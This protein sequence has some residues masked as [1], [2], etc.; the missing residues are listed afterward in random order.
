MAGPLLVLG[1]CG[2]DDGPTGSE[3]ERILAEV[4]LN[5]TS[6]TLFAG[7]S[8]NI[9]VT[10]LDATGA[11]VD[12]STLPQGIVWASTDPNVAVASSQ[13]L[14]SALNEGVATISA[15]AGGISAAIVVRVLRVPSAIV[16]LDGQAKTGSV[17]DNIEDGVKMRLRDAVGR[18]VA[19]IKVRFTVLS[20]GGTVSPAEI[21]TDTSGLAN[22]AWKLGPTAGE[23]R[24][25]VRAVLNSS[26]SG[27]P[28]REG[29]GTRR[30]M[31]DIVLVLT[32][33][34]TADPPALVVLTP[35]EQTVASG[36]T[37]AVAFSVLDAFGNAVPDQS[38][39][40]SSSSP[41]VATPDASGSFTGMKAGT[42]TI[43]GTLV[44]NALIAGTAEVTVTPGAAAT[45]TKVSGD[46]Q[47]GLPS[48]PLANPLVV[49]V[50]DLGGNLLSGITVQWAVASGSGTLAA[51]SSITDANGRA[52]ATLTFGPTAGAVSV[53]AS[54][55]GP[56]P[57]AFSASSA[58]L[59]LA[60]TSGSP[61]PA[62]SEGVAYA[63][64]LVATGGSGANTWVLSGAP[65]WLSV[66]ASTGA[67]SGTA[68]P[69]SYTFDVEVTSGDGQTASKSFSLTVTYAPVTITTASPLPAGVSGTAYSHTVAATGGNGGF[70][71]SLA[72]APA[73]LSINATTGQLS[74]TAVGGSYSF[75]VN[76]ASGDGQNASKVFGLTVG[77]PT[78]SITTLA[79]PTGM[80]DVA[81]SHALTAIGGNGTNTWSL[82]GGPAWLTLNAS[83]GVLSGTAQPGEYSL[84]ISVSSGDGQ[85]A[86][87]DLLLVVFSTPLSIATASALPGGANGVAYALTFSATGGN[88]V[89]T[90]S[91]TGAPAWLSMNAST[92]QI[93]G[94]AVAGGYNFTVNVAS[95]DGQGA[96]KAVTLNV[97]G[98]GFAVLDITTTT[99]PNG[100]RTVAYSQTLAATGGNG[101]NTWALTAGALPA[102][103]S[104]TP[105]TGQISGTPTAAGTFNFT[106]QATS[107]DAQVDTQAL[108]I[109]VVDPTPTITTAS[110]PNGTRTVA[111]SQTLAA[112]GGDGV[113]YA[114][115]ITVGT[116]PAGLTLNAGTGQISGTPTAAGTSN[117]TVR[118]TSGGIQATRA[119]SI[120]VVH[121]A[122]TVTTA[123]LPNGTRTVAY[124]QTLAAT[125]G[126]GV[127]YTWAVTVGTLP[128]GLTLN[129]G[130]GQI[131][132]T[133]TAAGTSNFTVQVTSGGLTATQA[134]GI[135]VVHPAPTIT[136]ASLP[137]GTRTVAY[138]QT[139]A[140]TGG[141]GVT[142]AWAITVGTLPAGLTLNAGTGQIS[143]TP[144]AAGTSNFT[145][146]VTSGGLTATQALGIT[147]VHPAPSITTTTLP[148][149]TRTVAYSQTLAATAGDGTTYTW[150]V[151]VG[152]LPAGLT[153][154]AGTGQI[155]GTPTA[156]GTTNFTVQVTSGGLTAT[157]ALSITVVHP[158]PTITT[159]SLPNGTR[160]VAYNQSLAATGGDGV[161]YAWAI[162]AGS[163][164]AG[165]TLNAGTGAITGTPTAA[166]SF[167]VTYQ[168]TSGGLSVTKALTLT[169]VH[170]APAIT[171][172]TVPD[173]SIGV[174]Y[175][176]SVAATGG[177][178]TFAWAISAGA[179]PG[180]LTL[181]AGSGLISGTPTAPP[182]TF[183]FT[184]QVTSD[185]RTAT[186]ALSITTTY[187]PPSIQST[188]LPDVLVNLPYDEA[189][190]V[191]G[192]DGTF[193]WQVLSGSLPTG[194]S[195]NA[196]TGAISGTP[197]VLGTYNFTLRVTSAAQTDDQAL[198]IS[199]NQSSEPAGFTAIVDRPFNSKASGSGDRGT[200]SFPNK[201][202]GSEGWDDFESR[203]PNLTIVAG[204]DPLSPGSAMR[205]TYP[206]GLAVAN[207]PG[208]TQTLDFTTPPSELYVRTAIMLGPTYF[209]NG[210]S[211][212]LYFH[213]M[214]GS[215]RGEPFLALFP[216]T[217]PGTFRLAANFQG[218]PDNPLGWF[219]ATGKATAIERQR[220][221]V[222]ETHLVMNSAVGVKD[223]TFR[224]WLN[225]QLVLQRTDVEFNPAGGTGKWGT[226]HVSPTFGGG[227]GLSVNPT[228]FYWDLGH[229]Y[230]SGRN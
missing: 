6:L 44:S 137:N 145:V 147:V 88:G 9:V 223:G 148:N 206:V 151:T 160:T 24:L 67:L 126:D 2:D 83:T 227:G 182:G 15:T 219:D 53:T 198:S 62:G 214:T 45:L 119:L 171:T 5:F 92:G 165:L 197:T 158:A 146:Q 107:G 19:G 7:E 40:F 87:T 187:P 38:V 21:V 112:T 210:V 20:G 113:T 16:A 217:L 104:L 108:S 58:F 213:R 60:I 218:T 85:T 95:G 168:V 162:T 33:T 155:S 61:L 111:Y 175:S 216:G 43:T 152:A 55:T 34:A 124:S 186:Q 64:A 125:G 194:T 50:K 4:R 128:A 181:N 65:A 139:L 118:V 47:S 226:L 13:G 84:T 116:L 178:G 170:P 203:E 159:A 189:P 185:A 41:D 167:P 136:T 75:T 98:G 212:K 10:V 228:Q 89:Y 78:L 220:W 129:A 205:I 59:P 72:G 133:P 120:T 101:V 135:T 27:A 82:S 157:Q 94:V 11:T 140:A 130:T 138:S 1:A 230:V 93:T 191:T 17:G 131:S 81:Y 14:I 173:G 74:G 183:N 109:T 79:L 196:T 97:S 31:D 229:A 211:N 199:V 73:W 143:G 144:T 132:G 110:L 105:G 56:A 177:D 163:L 36:T 192:G 46:G 57:V 69:G 28:T 91:L 121:S 30:A 51:P 193:A 141:D 18:G 179:L 169:V 123:S 164:A 63:A 201:T 134:L 29:D 154:T 103:L 127:T 174:A 225:G 156:A 26:A 188:S 96:S 39:T 102:G 106:V 202:G 224:V 80:Q 172:T 200:G 150:A 54:T 184:V 49:E 76:V 207:G 117:F 122:P 77:F 114:W 209:T 115:A 23:Q 12:P 208:V 195:L 142:Y 222:I 99:L 25:E 8:Q 149:G 3:V 22:S 190:T 48:A 70:T 42:T 176:Q 215:P 204:T 71:W 153:L 52:S 68:Q 100:T 32:A 180:G 66:D 221:Y 86:S 90:W 35:S 161:T 37:G 166:G